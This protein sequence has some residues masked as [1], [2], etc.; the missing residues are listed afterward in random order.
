ML[1]DW[2]RIETETV[3]AAGECRTVPAPAATLPADVTEVH[4]HEL[5]QAGVDQSGVISLLAPGDRLVGSVTSGE[6]T[7]VYT[8]DAAPVL[9][10][11]VWEIAVRDGALVSGTGHGDA[12]IRWS[13]SPKPLRVQRGIAFSA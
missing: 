6:G 9:N 13:G 10:G 5:D 12:I 2:D 8:I 7:T 4:L 11:S 3:P 1:G